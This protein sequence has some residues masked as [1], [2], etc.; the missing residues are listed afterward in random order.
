L[1][2]RAATEE[3]EEDAK[4]SRLQL[5]VSEGREKKK[6]VLLAMVGC[7]SPDEKPRR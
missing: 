6:S 1:D 4:P 3:E 5:Q 7:E 2:R